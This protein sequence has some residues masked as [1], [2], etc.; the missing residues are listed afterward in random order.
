MKFH[1][2]LITGFSHENLDEK[3][4]N[5]IKGFCDSLVFEPAADVDGLLCRFNKVDKQLIDQFPQLKY[6]GVL[7]TG[8]GTVDTEYAK[9]KNIVVSN[10]PGYC[11]QSVGEYVFAIILEHLR[12]LEKAKQV[13]RFGDYSGDGFS[14]S[15]IA[16]KKLGV[17]GLGRIGRKVAE[18][19]AFGFSAKVSYWSRNRKPEVEQ[20][21]ISYKEIDALVVE[22]DF[23]SLHLNK[24]QE[25]EKILN[26]RLFNLIKPGAVLINVSPMELIELDALEARLKQGN[27][28]FIFDHPDEMEKKE[29]GRLVQYPNCIVYP[30]IGFITKEARIQKQMIFISNLE[31]Y[32]NGSPTNLVF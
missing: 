7:A 6:I 26:K 22:S 13:A 25:T 31:N 9:S 29:V 2:I 18:I 16:D 15:E 21:G 1:K 3:V 14:A 10:I 30:P 32:L 17:I 12:Q 4:W 27:L 19:G 24:T 11:T 20:K 8:Y 23:L 5:Q 28:T